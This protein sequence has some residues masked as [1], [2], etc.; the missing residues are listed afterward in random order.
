MSPHPNPLP[1]LAEGELLM[2]AVRTPMAWTAM[3]S[4]P[5]SDTYGDMEVVSLLSHGVGGDTAHH[6]WWFGYGVASHYTCW[7]PS[8]SGGFVGTSSRASPASRE[9]PR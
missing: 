7:S 1:T 3:A 4:E 8:P 9:L 5:L 6:A 2:M